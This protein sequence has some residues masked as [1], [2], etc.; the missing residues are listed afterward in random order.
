MSNLELK[1]T[2]KIEVGIIPLLTWYKM[3]GGTKFISQK[4]DNVV[5]LVR[6]NGQSS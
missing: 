4:K 1:L 6:D 3:L 2:E 5:K